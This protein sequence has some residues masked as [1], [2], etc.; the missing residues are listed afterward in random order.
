MTPSRSP[1]PIR[2]SSNISNKL[3]GGGYI[4]EIFPRMSNTIFRFDVAAIVKP[5]HSTSL[6]QNDRDNFAERSS[7]STFLN[8]LQKLETA[9]YTGYHLIFS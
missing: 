7:N 5:E 1:S 6:Q 4:S 9:G 3:L 8:I 2:T